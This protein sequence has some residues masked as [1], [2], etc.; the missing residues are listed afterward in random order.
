MGSRS[1]VQ[2]KP[3]QSATAPV[4]NQVRSRPFAV[5]SQP[6][7]N[8]IEQQ[9]TP[10]L[11]TQL[12]NAQRFGHSFSKIA[13]STP[14]IIQPKLTIGAPGDK[15]EQEADRVA[16]Q[17]MSTS[18]SAIQQSIQRKAMPEE[19][20]QTK[21]LG[22]PTLRREA[23]PQE[24][25]IQTKRSPDADFQAGSNL[26]SRLNR[27][28]GEGSPLPDE[29][30]SFME[31]R[32][33]TDF[34]QVKVHADS[35]SVQMNQELNA[36]AF[37]HGQDVYFGAGKAAANDALTAHEL[38]HVVQQTGTVQRKKVDT[39]LSSVHRL[40]LIQREVDTKSSPFLPKYEND[41]VPGWKDDGGVPEWAQE[42]YREESKRT[43]ICSMTPDGKIGS[44]YF[45]A[46]GRIRTTHGAGPAKESHSNLTAVQFNIDEKRAME[47]FKSVNPK[48]Y[49]SE[50]EMWNLFDRWLAG[51]LNRATNADQLPG[52][53]KL[54]DSPDTAHDLNTGSPPEDLKLFEIFK[55]INGK[56][57]S[58]HPSRGAAAKFKTDKQT[59][60]VLHAAI[61]HI[62][63]R[64]IKNP[65][66]RNTAFYAFVATRIPSFVTYMRKPAEI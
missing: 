51:T 12:E 35:E 16:E 39:D 1:H 57:E 41:E 4:Q 43:V 36:Q 20:V 54:V 49:A 30:R 23:M 9:A 38:T 10:D 59:I 21:S 24:V 53:M 63:E 50:E 46:E 44:V 19:E 14:A 48:E 2:K 28:Q 61:K 58:W 52:W 29:V 25:E 37:T 11:Q 33:G 5:P 31:P 40:T 18:E 17:V 55:N 60:S 22:N 42:Q 62:D 66:T 64:G 6:E 27:S 8:A 56:V 26:E 65:K 47:E 15:Y 7:T 45:G 3:Q 13:A 32:F 34:S